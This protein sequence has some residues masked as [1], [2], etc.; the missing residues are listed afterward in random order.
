MRLV[1]D[2]IIDCSRDKVWRAF[3]NPHNMSKWM[4]GF[5]SFEPQD[6][7]PGQP[8]AVSKLTFNENGRRIE[9]TETI[10]VRNEPEEFSGTY[11]GTNFCNS[12]RNQFE[13]LPGGKTRWL[14][15]T[16]MQ[17]SGFMR[18][19]SLIAKPMIRKLVAADM[20]RFKTLLEAG[21]LSLDRSY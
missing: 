21:E 19:M 3:D 11:T 12:I 8:G 14:S 1:L 4:Q 15:E 10:T 9:F 13:S 18:L 6:G 16:D 2:T 17:F 5:E 7:T 20:E